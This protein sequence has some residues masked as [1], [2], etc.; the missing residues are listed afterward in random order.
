MNYLINLKKDLINSFDGLEPDKVQLHLVNGELG[1]SAPVVKYIARFVLL[2]CRI[3]TPFDV[4][5]FIR[6]WFDAHGHPVPDIHF[7][8]EVI[9]LESYDL[10]IDL[11]LSDKIIITDGRALICPPPIWSDGVGTFIAGAI[12]QAP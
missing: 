4:L 12:G 6:G 2:D 8:C 9:D 5:A 10:Q 7:G 3:A 11:G 1:A